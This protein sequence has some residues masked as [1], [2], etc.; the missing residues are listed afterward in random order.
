MCRAYEA[1]IAYLEVES[2]SANS[3]PEGGC[4]LS[5]VRALYGPNK[6]EKQI[7][8]TNCKICSTKPGSSPKSAHPT[9]YTHPEGVRW[10][11][12]KGSF[13]SVGAAVMSNRNE[14]AP[15]GLVTDAHLCDGFLHLIMIKD[16]PRALYLW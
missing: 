14:K 9:P 10:S 11:K 15:D 5:T 1:E 6:S 3:D 8:R 13:L 7:C 16:C 12:S 4:I 2:E